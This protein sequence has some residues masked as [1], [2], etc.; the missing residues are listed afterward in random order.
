MIR[1]RFIKLPRSIFDDTIPRLD[2]MREKAEVGIAR[3]KCWTVRLRQKREAFLQRPR[4][5]SGDPRAADT[6]WT[7]TV[8][9]F[10]GPS[11]IRIGFAIPAHSQ[12]ML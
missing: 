6:A 12:F 1:I 11:I 4:D 10:A 7:P 9:W 5:E 3:P 8:H 2:A